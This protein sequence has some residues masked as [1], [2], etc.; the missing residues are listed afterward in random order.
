MAA[1]PFGRCERDS[2]LAGWKLSPWTVFDLGGIRLTPCRIRRGIADHPHGSAF[3][4]H[5]HRSSFDFAGRSR[6]A[7]VAGFAAAVRTNRSWPGVPV[8]RSTTRGAAMFAPCRLLAR[9]VCD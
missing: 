8:A 3:V 1:H 4:A 9:R 7:V 6:D 5:D 2:S